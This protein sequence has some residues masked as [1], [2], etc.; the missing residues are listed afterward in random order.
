MYLLLLGSILPDVARFSQVFFDMFFCTFNDSIIECYLISFHA[1]FM[2][3]LLA[4]VIGLLTSNPWRTGIIVFLSAAFH[5]IL[6]LTEIDIGNKL[7][8][9]YPFSF[10]EISLGWFDPDGTLLL[11]AAV[12]FT[13][14]FVFSLFD[15][16]AEPIS[17]SKKRILPASIVLITALILP[18][19]TLHKMLDLNISSLGFIVNPEKYE[20]KVIEINRSPVIKTDPLTVDESGVV[21]E[22]TT[23][24]KFKKGDWLSFR[25]IYSKGKVTVLE[26]ETHTGRTKIWFSLP[27]LIMFLFI[28]V[29]LVVRIR[30][31]NT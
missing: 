20:N 28:T 11:S 18:A 22:L 24:Q 6:D 17:L 30:G 4:A 10:R 5:L 31:H 27:A 16:F 26:M 25:G 13:A 29:R 7:P 1:F 19:I 12:I 3:L 8:A 23:D 15:D 21:M 14:V 2:M 9:F